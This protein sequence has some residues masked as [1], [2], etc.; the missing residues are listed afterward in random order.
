MGANGQQAGSV[1]SKDAGYAY[2]P[3]TGNT[4][5]T[6][7]TEAG[8]NGLQDFRKVSQKNIDDDRALI[9]RLSDVETK[10]GRYDDAMESTALSQADQDRLAYLI[11]SD[12][13]QAHLFG[14]SVPVDE[15]N[16]FMRQHQLGNFDNPQAGY[17]AFSAYNNARESMSGYQRVLSGSGR[18]SDKTMELNIDAL[19]KPTDPKDFIKEGIAQFRENIPI[20][21]R[22][23]PILPGVNGGRMAPQGQT[24][25]QQNSGG[26]QPGATAIHDD[27][28]RW[29]FKGGNSADV[30]NWTQI[31][32]A[33]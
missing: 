18:G 32:R 20:M 1:K 14:S 31:T 10:L 8:Q 6:T 24:Q 2:D 33:N 11:N 30:K 15:V 16:N 3:Q 17:R 27:G 29:R 22:G 21:R 26:L 7:R 19:P 28:T 4:L 9:N 12:K 23:L 5:L 25:P 13:F